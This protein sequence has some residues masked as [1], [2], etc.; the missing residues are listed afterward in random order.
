VE[1]T[2]KRGEAARQRLENMVGRDRRTH[3]FVAPRREVPMA[4]LGPAEP[5]PPP[6]PLFHARRIPGSGAEPR[7]R[8]GTIPKPATRVDPKHGVSPAIPS[9]SPDHS[10]V[11]TNGINLGFNTFFTEI[12]ANVGAILRQSAGFSLVGPLRSSSVFDGIPR[13]V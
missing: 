9:K 12:F 3:P 2:E 8:R 5:P 4:T 1:E 13:A 11:I 10:L 6:E 7:I